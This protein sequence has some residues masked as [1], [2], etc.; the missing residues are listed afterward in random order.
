MTRLIRTH[1]DD[2]YQNMSNQI[3]VMQVLRLIKIK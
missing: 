2:R 1:Y 3:Y